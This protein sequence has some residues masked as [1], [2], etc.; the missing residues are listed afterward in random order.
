MNAKVEHFY[1]HKVL[2]SYVKNS[3]ERHYCELELIKK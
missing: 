2:R 1:D 3:L